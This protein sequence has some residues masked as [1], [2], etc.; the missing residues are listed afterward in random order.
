[1]F[2]L[3]ELLDLDP[4][5]WSDD[6]RTDRINVPGTVADT[7]WTWRMPLAIESLAGRTGLA[8]RLRAMVARRR[9][10]EAR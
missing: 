1:M 5:L 6:P 9:R 4:E 3:Q 10:P 8:D 7:N 2:Q